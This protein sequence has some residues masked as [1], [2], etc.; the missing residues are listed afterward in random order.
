MPDTFPVFLNG[1]LHTVAVGTTIRQLL[2]TADPELAGLASADGVKATDG[3]GIP[4]PLDAE[5]VAG[6][7]LRVFR[8]ARHG[9]AAPD[10]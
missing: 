10:A 3:R 5:L 1:A 2:L 6:A 8:S 7:I 4:V 9:E